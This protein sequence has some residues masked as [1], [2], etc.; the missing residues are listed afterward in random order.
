MWD[1]NKIAKILLFASVLIALSACS[2]GGSVSQS[3]L[4]LTGNWVGTTVVNNVTRTVTMTLAQTAIGTVGVNT[5]TVDGNLLI[6][7][8]CVFSFSGGTLN[9]ETSV[10]VI[11]AGGEFSLVSSVSND[12][13][14][15]S[16]SSLDDDPTDSEGC[17]TFQS[18]VTFTRA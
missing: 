15:G 16:F 13:I 10:L 12:S 5:T 7:S 6:D 9:F 3:G 4:N 17:G 1:T 2:S 11:D 8:V 14:S 18:S